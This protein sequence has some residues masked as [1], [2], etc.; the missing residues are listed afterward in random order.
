VK[1][2]PIGSHT[3]EFCRNDRAIL[4][5]E[6]TGIRIRLTRGRRVRAHRARGR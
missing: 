4:F 2:T 1:V 5:E 3:G 6:P